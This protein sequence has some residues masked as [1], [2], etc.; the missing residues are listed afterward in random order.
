MGLKIRKYIVVLCLFMGT[1]VHA[2]FLNLDWAKQIGDTGSTWNN[3][4]RASGLAVCKSGNVYTMGYF[5]GTAD[6]DPGPGTLIL[7]S[8]G[9]TDAFISKHDSLGRIVWAK[10]LGNGF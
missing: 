6:F 4:D 1:A 8:V 3:T 5:S 2:Q 7:T 9:R 10:Q